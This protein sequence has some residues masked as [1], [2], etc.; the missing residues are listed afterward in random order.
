MRKVNR[1]YCTI[2]LTPEKLRHSGRTHLLIKAQQI[3]SVTILL[4]FLFEGIKDVI[5]WQEITEG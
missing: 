1:K 2:P 4:R 3:L 5:D